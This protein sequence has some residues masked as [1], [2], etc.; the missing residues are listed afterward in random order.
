M[1]IK[2][3]KA[4]ETA[5]VIAPLDNTKYTDKQL[6]DVALEY[7]LGR[8]TPIAPPDASYF[9]QPEDINSWIA[10]RKKA[11]MNVSYSCRYTAINRFDTQIQSLFPKSSG[12]VFFHTTNWGGA[13]Q[14]MGNIDRTQSRP[15]LD[16]GYTPSFYV[17]ES[18]ADAIDW[19]VKNSPNWQDEVAILTFHVP[20]N[21][22]KDFEFKDLTEDAEEWKWLVSSFRNCKRTSDVLEY[23]SAYDFIYGPML[24]NPKHYNTEGPH[25]H[26]PPVMQLAAKNDIAT[27][28]LYKCMKGAFVFRKL[29]RPN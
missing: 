22:Q 2:P 3:S 20:H 14:I 1:G 23:D 12:K 26:R 28:F 7:I 19:G 9:L 17:S 4:R 29:Y 11:I 16:F 27:R 24:A 18:V 10:Y 21:F 5:I 6:L 8:Y 13:L 25:L 15:C